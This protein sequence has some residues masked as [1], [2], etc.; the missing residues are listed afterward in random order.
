MI[1]ERFGTKKIVFF[2]AGRWLSTMNHT[3]IMDLQ[4]QFAYIID[5]SYGYLYRLGDRDYQV[6]SPTTIQKE[7]SCIIVLTSPI[8]M[9]DMF[10]QLKSMELSDEIECYAF[11]FMQMI[12]PN[13]MDI[14]LMGEVIKGKAEEKIPRIIHSFWFSGEQ[15]PYAY[16]KCI[17]TWGEV[18][19]D[20]EIIEWNCENYNWKKH[21]FIECAIQKKAWAYASDYARLDVL[22]TY[23]GIYLD[24]DV[25]VFKP[26]DDLLN[27]DAILS[28]SNHVQIDLAV[29]GSTKGNPLIQ[30][31][32]KL[33]DGLELPTEKSQFAKFFQPAFVREEL[34]KN[35]IKM[36]GSL[37]KVKCAT[38]FPPDFFMPM[39]AI[40]YQDFE[41]KDYTHCVHYDNFGWSFSV[42]NKKEKKKKDNN[43]L[44]KMI[45]RS[46]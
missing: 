44:W 19:K 23:G 25:E 11:P 39:D 31:L 45:D 46:M 30:K 32:L 1:K 33:Y 42:D 29:I 10:M 3:E 20:Y 12:T 27:N 7:T 37:Q 4:E 22:N 38:C 28:F 21:P 36:N 41:M 18:L 43:L 13:K 24:M 34:I 16:Q 15:K 26:F 6:C 40:L 2:G 9:Y 14:S 17:D 5:N 35:G 8:Y